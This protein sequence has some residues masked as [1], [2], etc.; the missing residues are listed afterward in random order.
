MAARA[1]LDD[2]GSRVV[3]LIS[4]PPSSVD[5]PHLEQ[6]RATRQPVIGLF[7]QVDLVRNGRLTE[8][9]P[10]PADPIST[11]AAAPHGSG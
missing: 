8:V 1:S 10:P 11:I 6:T 7:T 3:I 4:A 2:S 9:V 5:L